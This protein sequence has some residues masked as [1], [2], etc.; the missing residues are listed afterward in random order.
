VKDSRIL[1]F[2]LV[3]VICIAMATGLALLIQTFVQ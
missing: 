1:K 2:A 3:C